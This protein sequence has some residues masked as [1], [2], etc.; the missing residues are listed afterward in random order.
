LD[1]LEELVLAQISIGIRGAC[2][3][4]VGER[5][6]CVGQHTSVTG[7]GAG[8][9]VEQLPR[10]AHGTLSVSNECSDP[11]MHTR[12]PGCTTCL[13]NRSS[14]GHLRK[15]AT[16]DCQLVRNQV[17]AYPTLASESRLLHG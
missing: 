1:Q 3:C 16:S 13:A 15:P 7:D 8:I 10:V 5:V 9:A 2:L 6:Y 12:D 11:S 17:I 14:T 4:A